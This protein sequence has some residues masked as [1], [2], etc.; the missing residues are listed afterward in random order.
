MLFGVISVGSV[1]MASPE[2]EKVP[3]PGTLVA[4]QPARLEKSVGAPR[5]VG[6]TVAVRP[7][8][9]VASP[10]PAPVLPVTP[11]VMPPNPAQDAATA[12]AMMAR[13]APALRQPVISAAPVPVV[14]Q[15]KS[16]NASDSSPP[17]KLVVALPAETSKNKAKAKAAPIA[18][19]TPRSAPKVVPVRSPALHSQGETSYPV[20]PPPV[21]HPVP[22]PQMTLP[23]AMPVGMPPPLAGTAPAEGPRAF[24]A[25]APAKSS[26]TA[27]SAVEPK[28]VRAPVAEQGPS[29]VAVSGE[30]AWIRLDDRRTVT[31][32]KGQSLEGYGAFIGMARGVAKFERGSI[33]SKTE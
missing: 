2:P 33:A 24:S 23:P 20:L 15:A 12:E 28:P 30:K 16:A 21:A 32:T 11:A 5:P 27:S 13:L 18:A 29:V 25:P 19:P 9:Q 26:P 4:K 8:K 10:V 1:L 7:I 17:Q 3:A 14:A 6:Q 31:V 22:A